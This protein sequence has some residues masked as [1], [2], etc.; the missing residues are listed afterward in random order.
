MH[1]VY[2]TIVL[3]IYIHI[4]ICIKRLS[5]RSS[6]HISEQ[7]HDVIPNLAASKERSEKGVGSSLA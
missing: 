2:N 7:F 3:Y 5:K 6:K 4:Y 1:I